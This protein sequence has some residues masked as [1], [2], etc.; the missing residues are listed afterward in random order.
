M[1][2]VRYTILAL[3]I[4]WLS[5]CATID[6]QPELIQ[7]GPLPKLSA[8]KMMPKVLWKNTQTA[9]SGKS[10]ANLSLA[11]TTAEIVVADSKGLILALDRQTGSKK[12]VISTK[13]EIT[14]GPSVSEGH[15]L[16]G[17]DD[18]K[19]LA[20]QLS[21]GASLWE[22]KITGS[23]MAAPVG[24]FGAV[25]VH[26][27][28]G[29]VV[30]LNSQ[31]GQQLWRYSVQTPPLMLRQ[32]SSPILLNNHVIVGFSNG[33]LASLHRMDGFPEWERELAISK[34]RSD[35][36]RM[37][38]ISADPIIKDNRLYAVSYQGQ[39]AAMAVETGETLWERALSS[40]SGIAVS[41]DAVFVSDPNGVLWALNR[42]TGDVIWKQTE[43]M[44]RELSRPAIVEGFVVVGDNDGY[45]HWLSQNDGAFVGQS[46]IDSK[47]IKA[48]PVVKDNLVYVLGRSG[49]VAALMP[50]HSGFAQG[51]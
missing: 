46:L 47:G 28:D 20:Y 34:G 48:P 29:S 13:A 37:V 5:G 14:A 27:L 49:N 43:L 15:V 19:V 38:D 40:Y 3:G 51:N 50:V 8:N 9:G 10:D 24:G 1:R 4:L 39:I 25:F 11:V 23:V 31:N 41:T 36:Q 18:G 35:I 12:W 30:A 6:K 26:A 32:N 42:K 2:A 44:G 17:T 16:V 33:K 21:D 45:L 7:K 22:A